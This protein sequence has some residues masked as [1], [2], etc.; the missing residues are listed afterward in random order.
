[1]NKVKLFLYDFLT[2]RKIKQ[3]IIAIIVFGGIALFVHSEN[4][5][6]LLSGGAMA[7]V[8]LSMAFLT[9]LYSLFSYAT[10]ERLRAYLMLP[11]KRSE[12]FFSFV[13]TQY[14]SLLLERMSFVFVIAM[15]FA[16]DALM[17]IAYL[18]LSALI[19]LILDT[20][21][22]LS[23]NKKRMFITAIALVMIAA[24]YVLLIYSPNPII[25]FA[26]LTV[27]LLGSVTFLAQFEPKHLAISRE[28]KTKSSSLRYANY[29]FIISLRE[30][31][32]LINTITVFIFA[33][34]FA[35]IAKD[36][37]VMLN[38][39]WCIMAVN[40][41]ITTM[42]S[43]DKSLMRQ[44]KMLPKRSRLMNGIYGVFIATYF[45]I[46]NSYVALLFFLFGQ[47]NL[48]VI[49]TGIVLIILETAIVLLLERKYPIRSWQTKQEVWRNPRKY[50]LP[51]VVF[52]ITAIPLLFG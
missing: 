20:V 38:I 32:T 27:F 5:G 47:L 13:F 43:G 31:S 36:N 11:C 48:Y 50:I 29:F 39:A 8:G 23:L 51:I 15:F 19:T 44:E 35:F 17:L 42:F 18:A 3:R 7:S 52:A 45:T 33:G 28:G 40:T 22:L 4:P 21:I 6:W 9:T 14:L 25:N 2:N 49:L 10:M 46:A 37:P 30:K 16:K 26:V 41:P 12:V 1:M 24:M 34:G